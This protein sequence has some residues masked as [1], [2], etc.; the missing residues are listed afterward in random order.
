MK[1]RAQQFCLTLGRYK[2]LS[3]LAQADLSNEA[4]STAMVG[5]QDKYN[6]GRPVRVLHDA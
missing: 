5:N 4:D 3:G 2:S 6:Q 1:P